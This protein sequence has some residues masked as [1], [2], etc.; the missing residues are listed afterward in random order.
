M[1]N[2]WTAALDQ[3]LVPNKQFHI[4]IGSVAMAWPILITET[5]GNIGDEAASNTE[6]CRRNLDYSS[7]NSMLDGKEPRSKPC[8]SPNLLI[9]KP[10]GDVERVKRV[11]TFQN[12]RGNS[13]LHMNGLVALCGEHGFPRANQFPGWRRKA[14]CGG[15]WSQ[16]SKFTQYIY[17]DMFYL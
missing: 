7:T 15:S 3:C 8:M 5:A 16:Q 11:T 17:L 13:K 2:P 6:V 14:G 1:L 10:I 9:P 4:T 12:L